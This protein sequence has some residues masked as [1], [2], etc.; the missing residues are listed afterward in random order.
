MFSISKDFAPP[1]AMIQP[2]FMIGSIFYFLGVLF[3]FALDPSAG[4]LDLVTVGWIH[5]FMLGFVMMVIFGAMA[6][7]VPVVVEVGH[8]SVDLYY[9]IWPSLL[10][11]TLL[12]V[13]GFWWAPTILP[14]G[15]MLVLVAMVVFLF[16]TFLTLKKAERITLTVKSVLA[17]NI[18]LTVAIIIG[19]LMS[20]AIGD[21]MVLDI[22]KWLSAHAV[23]V[24]GGYVTLTIIG[25]SMILL[26]MFGLS[27]G[28]DESRVNTAFNLM[29]IG[30]SLYVVATLI[31]IEVLRY[32]A[33]VVM[34]ISVGYYI[35]QIWIIYK[36]R[37][38]KAH[39]IWAK[40]MYVGY[41]A[42]GISMILGLVTL[43]SSSEQILL[44]AVW[45]F[46][47]G[48]VTFLINGHLYKIVPFLVWFERY[49]PLVGK[50]KVPMLH[51][52]FPE[53]QADYQFRFSSVGM[54]VSGFGLLF[55]SDTLFFGGVSFMVVGA[56]F[57]LSSVK[58]MLAYGKKD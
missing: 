50:E 24:L 22:N 45:F 16:E 15:G 3:L 11:G 26:P 2:F 25:L 10:V 51:E 44:S 58:F 37:A 48:F 7:L 52:M 8:F 38:R 42:L 34:Y 20:L 12:M 21:G 31:D 14:Y 40:S 6:Q 18:F 29:V 43:V 1:F 47:M 23:L 5:W 30:V 27:H 41:S 46:I 56:G 19:F 32:A 49:S 9:V 33:L 39:D 54:A 53:R 17:S 4:H 55:G 35:R 57:M 13:T 28:F 36:T